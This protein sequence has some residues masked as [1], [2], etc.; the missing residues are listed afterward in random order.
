MSLADAVAEFAREVVVALSGET[1]RELQVR[2]AELHSLQ[3]ELNRAR[4]LAADERAGRHRAERERDEL[5][6]VIAGRGAAAERERQ[7]VGLRTAVKDVLVND[8][9]MLD[10][11]RLVRLARAY[12]QSETP[13]E[14][15]ARL[16]VE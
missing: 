1:G 4:K 2:D 9:D 15:A 10:D 7:L 11:D 13:A 8:R 3:D 5:R 12:R 16:R 6:M 14:G